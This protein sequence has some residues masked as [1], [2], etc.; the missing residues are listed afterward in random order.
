MLDATVN[1]DF[2]QVEADAGQVDINLRA[3]L[4]YPEKRSF[5][6]EGNDKFKIAATGSSIIDPIYS[7]VYTRT[8]VNPISGVKLTG[9][10]NQHNSVALLYAID[11]VNGF[12]N[13]KSYYSHL[14]VLRYKYNFGSDNY[15]GVL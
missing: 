12:S 11:D 4:F 14:P 1:P 9:N 7:M 5:F 10:I 15:I 3:Q 2:S 13:I 6:L 8:I